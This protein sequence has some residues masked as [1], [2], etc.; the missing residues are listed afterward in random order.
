MEVRALCIRLLMNV[1][2]LLGAHV[3]QSYP[4]AAVSDAAFRI[5]PTRLQFFEYESVHFTCEGFND[6]AGGKVRNMKKFIPKCSNGTET[7]TVTCTIGF[8]FTSDSG[9]YWCEG[10]GGRSNS[11]NITV[12]AGSV[13]LQ[14]PVRPVMEGESVTLRCRNKMSST[15]FAAV[16][17]YKNGHYTGHSS[18]GE[19]TIH[20]VS[21]SDEGLYKCHISGAGVSPESWVAVRGGDVILESPALPVTEGEAVTLRCRNKETPSDLRADFYKDGVLIRSSSIGEMTIHSVSKSDEGLYKC[22]ISGAGGSV[23]S[24][25]AVRA[26]HGE[27]CVCSDFIYVLLVLRTVFT[28]VMVPLLLLLVG[29]LHCGKLRVTQ[30]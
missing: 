29:L 5:V 20:S 9:E 11:V 12:T 3:Q 30:K 26:Q 10:G 19:M 1:L 8:A 27:A 18:T 15:N 17:F 2:M 6:P 28:I 13:I 21:K 16:F 4:Q 7:S 24:W 22:H 14:S 23:E 25:M